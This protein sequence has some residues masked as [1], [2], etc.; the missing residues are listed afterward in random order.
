VLTLSKLRRKTWY[1]LLK[2]L[3]FMLLLIS[4]VTLLSCISKYGK[5]WHNRN[6]PETKQEALNDPKFYMVSDEDK[7]DVL[8][9]LDK[10]F[11]NLRYSDQKAVI[12][13]INTGKLLARPIHTSYVYAAYYTWNPGKCII[14]LMIG[15][16]L[17]FIV[18]KMIQQVFYFITLGEFYP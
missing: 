15:S 12:A 7:C 2:V 3:Y 16:L 1:K 4:I 18:F 8:S 9:L 11:N 17:C 5:D 13:Q 6:L 14:Y 10:E